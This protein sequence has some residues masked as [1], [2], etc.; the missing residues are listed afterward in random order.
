GFQARRGLR[1]NVP[2]VHRL[3]RKHRIARDIADGVDV[4]HIC[5]HL[6][7]N[8]DEA[9]LIHR[10]ARRLGADLPA[11]RRAAHRDQHH[12]VELRVFGIFIPLEEASA[13][14]VFVLRK[15]LSNRPALN[16]CQTATRSRSA[17]SIRPS[18]ISTTSRR[19]PSVEYTVPIS[20]PMMPPPITSSF[21]GRLRSSRAPVESTI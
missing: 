8:G 3:V 10:H 13:L 16:F 2:L 4:L 18:S 15:T 5:A 7:I 1:R 14:A 9:A 20:S 11:V 12:V 6:R 19:A 17:P 21:F